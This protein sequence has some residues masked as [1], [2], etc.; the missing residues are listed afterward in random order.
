MWRV[1][2]KGNQTFPLWI[3]GNWGGCIRSPGGHIRSNPSLSWEK[4]AP[5]DKCW[6]E[7]ETLWRPVFPGR[8]GT[9]AHGVQGHATVLPPPSWVCLCPASATLLLAI[10]GHTLRPQSRL[11][12]LCARSLG[13]SHPLVDLDTPASPDPE[14]PFRGLPHFLVPFPV[15]N[16]LLDD[17]RDLL[18]RGTS[19]PRICGNFLLPAVSKMTMTDIS[20][21][22]AACAPG[23]RNCFFGLFTAVSPG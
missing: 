18:E 3:P 21:L 17:H 15:R 14:S 4:T 10:R 2:G 22:S 11:G 9:L 23:G 12:G 20:A 16:H 19:W 1:S 6:R 13:Y 8:G 5:T 7:T